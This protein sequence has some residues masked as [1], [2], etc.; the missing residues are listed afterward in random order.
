MGLLKTLRDMFGSIEKKQETGPQIPPAG[1]KMNIDDAWAA[2][3]KEFK[4]L[5]DPQ[6]RAAV[7]GKWREIVGRDAHDFYDMIASH[8]N[9]SEITKL[10]AQTIMKAYLCGYMA[11]QG[12]VD[13]TEALQANLFLGREFRDDLREKGVQVDQLK[14]TLGTVMSDALEEIIK[15]GIGKN[16]ES[17]K[18]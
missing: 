4:D 17:G 16:P 1:G 3:W 11:R 14:P 9:M 15:L 12:W 2:H 10:E 8:P 7:L 18:S 6:T 13:E 5:P